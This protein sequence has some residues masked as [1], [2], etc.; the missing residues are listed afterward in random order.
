MV[1]LTD[2]MIET[3]EQHRR[4]IGEDAA[5]QLGR[6]RS[7]Q[8]VGHS[9]VA[10]DRERS[11]ALKIEQNVCTFSPPDRY[12]ARTGVGIV[13]GT[14]IGHTLQRPRPSSIGRPPWRRRLDVRCVPDE[15]DLVSG[16]SK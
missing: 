2:E 9:G 16:E 7:P 5:R 4:R 13:S 10:R 6:Y 11:A 12:K 8:R 15:F 14:E 1:R 3:D